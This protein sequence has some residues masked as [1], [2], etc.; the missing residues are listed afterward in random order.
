MQAAASVKW[1]G[2]R[3]TARPR[4]ADRRWQ[5]AVGASGTRAPSWGGGR[6]WCRCGRYARAGSMAPSHAWVRP[7]LCAQFD[8]TR[9]CVGSADEPSK[10]RQLMPDSAATGLLV[11]GDKVVHP[12]AALR[13][14]E[15]RQVRND[16][17]KGAQTH[18]DPPH[19]PRYRFGIDE[20]NGPVSTFAGSMV[21]PPA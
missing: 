1:S 12:S 13:C 9:F 17:C 4:S 8:A 15:H 6:K 7:R 10:V 18:L 11:A 14:V 3:A 21:S 20:M 16:R 5:P 19:S 2:G